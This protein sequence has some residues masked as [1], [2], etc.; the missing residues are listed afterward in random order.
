MSIEHEFKCYK[1][2]AAP[3]IL[4]NFRESNKELDEKLNGLVGKYLVVDRILSLMVKEGSLITS[5][6]VLNFILQEE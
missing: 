4:K 1:L 3:F 2:W 5:D 6:K